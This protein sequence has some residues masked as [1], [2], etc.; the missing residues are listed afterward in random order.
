MQKK[1]KE[2]VKKEIMDHVLFFLTVSV[3]CGAI[4]LLVKISMR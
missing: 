3:L 2:W 1:T 4:W